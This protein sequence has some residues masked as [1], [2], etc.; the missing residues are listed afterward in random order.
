M[1]NLLGILSQYYNKCIHTKNGPLRQS[2]NNRSHGPYR[3]LGTRLASIMLTYCITILFWNSS[4]RLLLIHASLAIMLKLC[5]LHKSRKHLEL[6]EGQTSLP[7]ASISHHSPSSLLSPMVLSL[8][9]SLFNSLLCLI[10]LLP[11]C[12]VLKCF[13]LAIIPVLWNIIDTSLPGPWGQSVSYS[14]RRSY[15]AFF[16]GIRILRLFPP[17]WTN[18]LASWWQDVH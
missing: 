13:C 16:Q 10:Y 7:L 17:K 18:N 5:S 14:P 12:A 1:G 11:H 2:C 15:F 3:A 9:W 8:C 6:E 4:M